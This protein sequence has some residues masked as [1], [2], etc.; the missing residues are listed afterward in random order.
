M[1]I[2]E[3][4]LDI[5]DAFGYVLCNNGRMSASCKSAFTG[6]GNA[7]KYCCT[8][9]LI[10]FGCHNPFM[11]NQSTLVLGYLLLYGYDVTGTSYQMR[12]AG[13]ILG[14][15]LTCFVFYQII[16]TELIKEI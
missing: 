10:F 3:S 15:V 9:V 2:W 8:A 6:T 14:A 5:Y 4:T 1:R 12:L 11:F 13:M 16:K 7:V